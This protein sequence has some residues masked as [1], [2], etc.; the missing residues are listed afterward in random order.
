MAREKAAKAKT[1]GNT[2]HKVNSTEPARKKRANIGE[3]AF[4]RQD[5][6]TADLSTYCSVLSFEPTK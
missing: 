3:T 5:I 2:R 1:S 6:K 4:D